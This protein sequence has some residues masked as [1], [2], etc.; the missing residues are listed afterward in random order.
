MVAKH[1]S[2]GTSISEDFCDELGLANESGN[3]R[4][5]HADMSKVL[6]RL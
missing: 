5:N 6:K 2:L 1:D 3:Q 4:N